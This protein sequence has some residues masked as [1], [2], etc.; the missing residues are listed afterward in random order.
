MA[1]R[2]DEVSIRCM[3]CWQTITL[4]EGVRNSWK[5]CQRCNFAICNFCYEHLENSDKCLSWFCSTCMFC[6]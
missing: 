4:E 2:M 3:G 5:M 6:V 1:L